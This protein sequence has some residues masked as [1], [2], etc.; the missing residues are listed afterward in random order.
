MAKLNVWRE[1]YHRKDRLT[2]SMDDKKI[3]DSFA[4][5]LNGYE[6]ILPRPE[7]LK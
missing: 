2:V 1:Y 3:K 7:D 4:R 5:H 6:A